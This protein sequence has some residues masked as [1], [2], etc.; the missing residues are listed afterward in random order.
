[1]VDAFTAFLDKWPAMHINRSKQINLISVSHWLVP[2]I[3][4]AF[5]ISPAESEGNH[6]TIGIDFNFRALTSHGWRPLWCGTWPHWKP[7][8]GVYR[9]KRVNSLY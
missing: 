5:I 7:N 1:M 9:C 2:Y 4:K 8:L 6:S 3:N